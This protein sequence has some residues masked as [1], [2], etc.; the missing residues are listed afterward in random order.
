MHEEVEE[1]HELWLNTPERS[2]KLCIECHGL[3]HFLAESISKM[4]YVAEDLGLL[5]FNHIL[6]I[7]QLPDKNTVTFICTSLRVSTVYDKTMEH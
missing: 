5:L 7:S 6:N 3:M 4:K 2:L 1:L